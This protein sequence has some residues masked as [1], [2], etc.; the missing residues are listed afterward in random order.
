MNSI[1]GIYHNG[2][3]DLLEKPK[4]DGPTEV[5]VIFPEKRKKVIAIKG[6]FKGHS[7]DY[8]M[9]EEDLK[10]LNAESEKHILVEHQENE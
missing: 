7:I 10:N 1:K 9:I 4:I 8:G 2:V 5:M 6:L 3:V